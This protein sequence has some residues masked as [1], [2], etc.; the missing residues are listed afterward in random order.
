MPL[1]R[2]GGKRH[3]IRRIMFDVYVLSWQYEVKYSGSR[4]LFHRTM[5]RET[6]KKGAERFAKKWGC[7][8]PEEST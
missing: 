5:T 8:M 7:P 2:S 6:D 3:H 1:P 4:L